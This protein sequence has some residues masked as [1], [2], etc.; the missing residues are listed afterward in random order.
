[1]MGKTSHI[2][3]GY[4]TVTPYLIVRDVAGLIDFVKRAFN[5]EEIG[6]PMRH[7]DGRIMHAEVRIGNSPVMMG[8][9]GD[10]NPPTAPMLHLYVE[11][12]DAVYQ[13]ALAAGAQS[14]RAPTDEFYGDRS[15]GVKD[16]FGNQWWIATRKETLT[17]DEIKRRMET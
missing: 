6:E 9:A 2:P 12:C 7:P 3:D 17:M 14:L 8:G 1:M 11:D 10:D 4:H 16:A 13:Q 15:A 5:A